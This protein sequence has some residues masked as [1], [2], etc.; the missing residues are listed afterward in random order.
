M[1]KE[2]YADIMFNKQKRRSAVIL[3]LLLVVISLGTASIF[4][5]NKDWFFGG[6][7]VLIAI[8]PIAL[9]PVSFRNYP[10]HGNPII[11]VTDKEITVMNETAKVKDVTKIKVLIELPPCGNDA[12][13]LKA[14]ED[15]K[16]VHPGYEF[17][18]NLD[19]FY[20]GSDG[21]KK[22]AYSHV[23]NVIE[24]L[25]DIIYV[26]VKN[27]SVTYSHKKNTALSEFD[28]R[29]VVSQKKQDENHKLTEKQKKRQ[30]I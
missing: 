25:E 15:I 2:F 3:N 4:L 1:K 30:L 27:Y 28:F 7:F 5:V 22:V 12:E 23:S 21:K 16:T 19:M 6:A 29:K 17:Y 24:A 10:I 20:V 9:I 14:L 11:T 8:L 26:G 18:G 13:S